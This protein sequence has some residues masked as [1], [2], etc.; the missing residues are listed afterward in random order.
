MHICGSLS[1]DAEMLKVK[2]TF[3][4]SLMSVSGTWCWDGW[5]KEPSVS[6]TLISP[7][8]FISCFNTIIIKGIPGPTAIPVTV[9]SL[10]LT[11]GCTVLQ[12]FTLSPSSTH[13]GV[14][15]K[16]VCPNPE[17]IA[18]LTFFASTQSEHSDLWKRANLHLIWTW[19]Q[20]QHPHP[21]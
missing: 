18:S 2:A 19:H 6:L 4:L 8:S 9:A 16:H 17:P 5:R 11:A 14:I 1:L 12:G 13:P 20:L 21:I 10:P 7:T 3:Y 15:G